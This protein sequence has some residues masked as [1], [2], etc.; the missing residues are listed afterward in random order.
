LTSSAVPEKPWERGNKQGEK[1][2][3]TDVAS[4]RRYQNLW[5]QT[6]NKMGT[7]WE[8]VRIKILLEVNLLI[9]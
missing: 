3:G 5:E 7:E 8:Q 1:A 6:G 9:K 4:A 2:G